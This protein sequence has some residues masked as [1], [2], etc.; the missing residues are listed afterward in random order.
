M[1]EGEWV[2]IPV[3]FFQSSVLPTVQSCQVKMGGGY[4]GPIKR[5]DMQ[6]RRLAKTRGNGSQ[7]AKVSSPLP[8]LVNFCQGDTGRVAHPGNLYRVGARREVH[9]LGAVSAP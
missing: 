3:S 5:A 9:N 1:S 4:C 8:D 7:N 2:K 6:F